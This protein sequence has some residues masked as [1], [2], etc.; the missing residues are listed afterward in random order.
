MHEIELGGWKA[1]FIHLLRMLESLD[2]SL[3]IELDRRYPIFVTFCASADN[4][5]LFIV[6]IVQPL[7]SEETLF[8]VS[9]QTVLK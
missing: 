8:G 7:R 9:Q 4:L 2:E 3:L 1:L 6:G 5:I